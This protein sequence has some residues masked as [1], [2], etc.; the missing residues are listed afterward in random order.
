MLAEEEGRVF[1]RVLEVGLTRR[2]QWVFL[3]TKAGRLAEPEWK[4]Q[5]Y[6]PKVLGAVLKCPWGPGRQRR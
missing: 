5:G 6:Q 1:Q 4:A 2:D 3:H